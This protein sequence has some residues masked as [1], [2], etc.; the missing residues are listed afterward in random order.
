[1]TT[2]ADL[3][4]DR[5]RVSG[6]L[7]DLERA[8]ASRAPYRTALYIFGKAELTAE[9]ELELE[10]Q[11]QER[12]DRERLDKELRNIDNKIYEKMHE[13]DPPYVAP[14]A[15]APIPEN[16]ER[17]AELN[18]AIESKEHEQM[19]N[20]CGDPA[21]SKQ[22]LAE[23]NQ[24]RFDRNRL[25]PEVISAE[26]LEMFRIHNQKAWDKNKEQQRIQDE[27]DAVIAS[28]RAACL[29]RDAAAVGAFDKKTIEVIRVFDDFARDRD[30]ASLEWTANA[31]GITPARY[32]GLDPDFTCGRTS[33]AWVI[34]TFMEYSIII[35]R[36]LADRMEMTRDEVLS[37]R[38]R[39]WKRERYHRNSLLQR[40]SNGRHYAFIRWA[41]ERW[42]FADEDARYDNC[43]VLSEAYAW[44]ELAYASWLM[45]T[46]HLGI[47]SYIAA[48]RGNPEIYDI[49]FD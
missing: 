31:L 27:K 37:T 19:M 40:A 45:A 18:A 20:C 9:D 7:A 35:A 1:M 24:L 48:G 39:P 23:L 46:F 30:L 34:V 3:E 43:R 11:Y 32:R 28:L 41:H 22:L 26:R 14:A 49:V 2:I 10:L 38:E 8:R 5:A 25:G 29:A 16:Q 6:E 36:W 13:S 15:P 4:A 21:R 42:G 12:R 33:L 17:I 47:P 44:G